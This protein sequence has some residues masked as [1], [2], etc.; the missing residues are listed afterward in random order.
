MQ[1]RFRRKPEA[2]DI[3]AELPLSA[4]TGPSLDVATAAS[5]PGQYAPTVSYL[6]QLLSI[7]LV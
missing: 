2:P 7:R 4:E 3:H 6:P 1:V 5:F